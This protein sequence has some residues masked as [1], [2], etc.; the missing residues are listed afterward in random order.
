MVLL[1]KNKEPTGEEDRR[2]IPAVRDSQM[3]SSM[4]SRSGRERL[5]AGGTRGRGLWHSHSEGVGT[6]REMY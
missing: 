4:A 2:M 5:L 1:L 6:G 3:Y